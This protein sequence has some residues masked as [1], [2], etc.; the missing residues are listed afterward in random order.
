MWIGPITKTADADTQ[1][2][3]SAKGSSKSITLNDCVKVFH[4]VSADTLTHTHA[5]TNTLPVFILATVTFDLCV[6][7]EQRDERLPEKLLCSTF[8]SVFQKT[9]Y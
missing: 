4:A 8:I 3:L 7:E 6:C 1:H 5:H 2:N 9:E